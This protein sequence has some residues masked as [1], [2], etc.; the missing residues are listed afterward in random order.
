MV[1]FGQGDHFFADVLGP[2]HDQHAG[3]FFDQIHLGHRI[4]PDDHDAV[5]DV[6]IAHMILGQGND[7]NLPVDMFDGIQIHTFS[8]DRLHDIFYRGLF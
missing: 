7:R 4:I 6:I 5:F 1:F 8:L 3:P 2:D